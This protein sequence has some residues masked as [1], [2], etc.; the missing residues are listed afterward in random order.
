MLNV[1]ASTEISHSRRFTNMHKFARQG[2][3]RANIDHFTVSF[4]TKYTT[5]NG[6]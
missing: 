6:F 3:K 4:S 1:L 2:E 5:T